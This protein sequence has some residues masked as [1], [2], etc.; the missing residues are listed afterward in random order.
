MNISANSTWLNPVALSV[1]TPGESTYVHS[2]AFNL[3]F[4]RSRYS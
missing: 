2:M 1:S 3:Y 4:R